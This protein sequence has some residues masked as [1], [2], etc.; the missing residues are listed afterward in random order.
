MPRRFARDWRGVTSIEFAIVMPLLLAM[1]LLGVGFSI[2][3]WK[4]NIVQEIA[5]ESARCAVGHALECALSAPACAPRFDPKCYAPEV[6][7]GRSVPHLVAATVN[8]NKA[9][10][11][12]TAAFTTVRIAYNMDVFGF[13]VRIS[14][15]GAYPN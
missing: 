12:G 11:I 13:T 6:A 2:A 5:Q 1:L 4:S 10:T 15:I 3:I 7:K 8:I 14:G 9:E